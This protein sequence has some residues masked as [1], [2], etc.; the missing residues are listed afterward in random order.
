MKKTWK[1]ILC[2]LMLTPCMFWAVACGDDPEDPV[3]LTVDLSVEQQQEA[4][5]TLRTLA[6]KALNNDGSK[7]QAYSLSATNE[8]RDTFD[9][10]N[11]GL[12]TEN[13]VIVEESFSM[14]T[15]EK[16]VRSVYGGYKTDNTGYKVENVKRLIT[17]GTTFVNDTVSEIVKNN[18]QY[19]ELY[20]KENEEKTL[21]KVNSVY[22]KESV[23]LDVEL[24]ADS[25]TRS[26]NMLEVFSTFDSKV[27][28]NDFKSQLVDWTIDTLASNCIENSHEKDFTEYVSTS[29]KFSLTDGVYTLDLDMAIDTTN[30]AFVYLADGVLKGEG[31]LTITFDN[32]KIRKLEYNYASNMVLTQA[33][34]SV[35][36][37][38]VEQ[39][40]TDKDVVLKT[41]SNIVN[42]SIDFM[43]AFDDNYYNQTLVGY[44]GT[45]ANGEVQNNQ[46]NATILFIDNDISV[47]PIETKL[48]T[49]DNFIESISY[50]IAGVLNDY[51]QTM[52]AC[53]RFVNDGSYM[54]PKEIAE[55]ELVSDTDVVIHV[56]FAKSGNVSS[57][58]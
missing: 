36:G 4:Y 9:V 6:A 22:A 48:V 38:V 12:T 1:K 51:S 39:E 23:V 28:F 44:L 25:L 29:Y 16:A 52:A 13:K 3:N 43:T 14:L 30:G 53:Y 2:S 15:S 45:G 35:F 46:I 42:L 11:A 41:K 5:T 31:G 20:K 58:S 21:S 56:Y 54:V 24:V 33:A 26:G 18:G 7:D 27:N 34:A 49:G 57:N 10:N 50:A 8:F 17:D 32:D 55:D 19:Y 47:A 40:F 37:G